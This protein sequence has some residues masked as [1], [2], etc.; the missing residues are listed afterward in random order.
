MEIRQTDYSLML[1]DRRVVVRLHR[2]RSVLCVGSA[3]LFK[4]IRML[5]KS[6]TDLCHVRP[7]SH[8]PA[9]LPTGGFAKN[10]MLRAFH[11]NLPRSSSFG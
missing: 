1:G 2:R 3:F 6:A 11:D 5:L 8:V 9:R 10:L 7:S 4:C